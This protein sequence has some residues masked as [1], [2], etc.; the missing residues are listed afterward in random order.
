MG[1]NGCRWHTL[2]ELMAIGAVQ[3]VIHEGILARGIGAG[4]GDGS[5]VD[6]WGLGG[7]VFGGHVVSAMF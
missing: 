1:S 6:S 3:Q 7:V 2:N 5:L 4:D